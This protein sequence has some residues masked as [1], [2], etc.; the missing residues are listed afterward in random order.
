MQTYNIIAGHNYS[1]IDWAIVHAIATR[2]PGDFEGICACHG[3]ASCMSQG[4]AS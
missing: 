4:D 3:S 2:H 1:G